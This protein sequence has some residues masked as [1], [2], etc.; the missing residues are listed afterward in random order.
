MKF[1]YLV[2]YTLRDVGFPRYPD[3]EKAVST[4]RHVNL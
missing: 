1:S 3:M 2:T 4:L